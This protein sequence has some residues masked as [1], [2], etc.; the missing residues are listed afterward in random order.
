MEQLLASAID[1]PAVSHQKCKSLA[2][3]LLA[4]LMCLRSNAAYITFSFSSI[5]WIIIERSRS[6]ELYLTFKG[7]WWC[8]AKKK[9]IYSNNKWVRDHSWSKF[10]LRDG[11]WLD[12]V[13]NTACIL[14]PAC[15]IGL[16]EHAYHLTWQHPLPHQRVATQFPPPHHRFAPQLPPHHPTPPCWFVHRMQ[17]ACMA[18]ANYDVIHDSGWIKSMTGR[19]LKLVARILYWR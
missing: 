19:V 2:V 9:W 10:V 13:A 6:K 11:H 3:W 5:K 18:H 16:L 12:D 4:C 17:H 14:L 7:S 1:I 8:V 15:V